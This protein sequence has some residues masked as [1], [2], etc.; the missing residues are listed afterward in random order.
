MILVLYD[1]W[2]RLGMQGGDSVTLFA[3]ESTPESAPE[4][5]PESSREKVHFWYCRDS[6]DSVN[7]FWH[8]KVHPKVHPKNLILPYV[9][10]I[11]L[12]APEFQLSQKL[13]IDPKVHNVNP[14]R[15]VYIGNLFQCTFR[16]TF[17]CT[18]G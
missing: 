2:F 11:G 13:E 15:T 4:S 9:Q 12:G 1:R 16:C 3:P 5:T 18:F 7:I 8:P 17:G 6:P 14:P 10:T